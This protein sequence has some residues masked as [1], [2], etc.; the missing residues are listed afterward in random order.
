MELLVL[1]AIAIP[2]STLV[3]QALSKE[4]DDEFDFLC[5]RWFEQL[6]P[7][8]LVRRLQWLQASTDQ[9][10]ASGGD[11]HAEPHFAMATSPRL[12]TRLLMMTA[13]GQRSN[14]TVAVHPSIADQRLSAC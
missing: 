13:I 11:S 4:S 8:F 3:M 9:N 2:F 5:T 12:S 6:D 10:G 1:A 14:S 7:Y